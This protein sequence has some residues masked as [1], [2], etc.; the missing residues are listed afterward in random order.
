MKPAG[1]VARR[2]DYRVEACKFVEARELV[3][4]HHYARG[5]ANTAVATHCLIRVSD[6]KL[7]GAAVWMPPTKVAAIRALKDSGLA[8]DWRQVLSLSRLVV[9][10][11]EP[12]NTAGLLLAGSR[13]LLARTDKRWVLGLTYADAAQGHT[14]TI[15]KATGWTESRIARRPDSVWV[16][17]EGR[18]VAR[19]S[20]KSRT[21]QQ[22]LDAGYVERP[23]KEKIRFFIEL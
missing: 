7:V 19:K 18:Q 20:T 14:G 16:D 4:K 6:G 17:A 13:R 12:K 9:S 15:Y 5:M 1:P 11:G 23:G 2:A 22:M 21:R 10:P 8:G 3:V